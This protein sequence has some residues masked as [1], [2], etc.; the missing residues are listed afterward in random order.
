MVQIKKNW[1]VWLVAVYLGIAILYVWD[2]GED[3]IVQVHDNLDNMIPLFKVLKDNKLFWTYGTTAPVLGDIDRNYLQSDL[4]AYSLLYY[5]MPTYYA[6]MVGMLSKVSISVVGSV[7]LGREILKEKYSK[8]KNWVVFVGFLYGISPCYPAQV[9]SFA[10]LPL[11]LWILYCIYTNEENNFKYQLFIFLYAFFSDFVTMGAFICG[12]LFIFIV[13]DGCR[14]KKIKKRMFL[15]FV[16]LAL[17]YVVTEHRIFYSMLFSNEISIRTSIATEYTSLGKSIFLAIMALGIGHYHSGYAL[18]CIVFPCCLLFW[19]YKNYKY[20]KNRQ[21]KKAVGDIYNILMLFCIINAAVYGLD[22]YE[23][24]CKV[25]EFLFP[26]LKGFSLART[27]WLNSFLIMILFFILLMELKQQGSRKI[28]FTV[29]L[30]SLLSLF[31]FPDVYN[32]ISANL[33]RDVNRFLEVK[34]EKLTWQEFY[35][36]DLFATIKEDINYNGEKSVAFEFHPAVLYYNGIHTL[37][38]YLSWYSQEY[39]ESFRKIIAPALDYNEQKRKYYDG[40]GGRAYVYPIDGTYDP[41]RTLPKEKGEI[42]FDP[43]SFKQMEGTYVFSRVNIVNAEEMGLVLLNTYTNQS[44]PYT[45]YLYKIKEYNNK[46]ER[47]NC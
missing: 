31:L 35:S 5:F 32:D 43:I 9:F 15:A 7:L 29:S 10:S 18:H 4:K 39:K 27:L 12:Y 38:G 8:W 14:N 24:V 42:Y 1:G 36:E 40:W 47:K 30:L 22:S 6:Y 37:D 13:W 11:L 2:H 28:L 23:P 26:F 25:K 17:G 46:E 44:S 3:V 16:L 33:C 21:L 19:A 41:V 20:F 34:E 45:I